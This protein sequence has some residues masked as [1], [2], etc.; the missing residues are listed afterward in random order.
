[1]VGLL[2]KEMTMFCEQCGAVLPEDSKFCFSCGAAVSAKETSEAPVEESQAEAAEPLAEDPQAEPAVSDFGGATE[3]TEAPASTEEP[4]A[5]PAPATVPEAA[6]TAVAA[7]PRGRVLLI[8]A[9]SVLLLLSLYHLIDFVTNI[10]TLAMNVSSGVSLVSYPWGMVVFGAFVALFVFVTGLLALIFSGKV[11]KAKFLIGAGATGIVLAIIR[12]V[13]GIISLGTY[14]YYTGLSSGAFYGEATFLL[15]AFILP[16]LA[17]LML[18]V[19]LILVVVGAILNNKPTGSVPVATTAA[20]IGAPGVDAAATG[21]AQSTVA[22]QPAASQAAYAQV[23]PVQNQAAASLP[24]GATASMVLGIVS[25]VIT[26]FGF[27]IPFSG[28]ISLITGIIGAI[29]G[30]RANKIA[31]S[32]QATLG[33]VLSVISLSLSALAILVSL[34]LLVFVGSIIGLESFL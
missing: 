21:A 2:L 25:I 16:L 12:F 19:S 15:T 1:L 3:A 17:T 7:K 20:A 9:G 32:P 6:P 31:K 24:E 11:A 23:A 30:S 13:Q 8:I 10:I 14:L 5:E 34:L 18:V 22:T 27:C 33:F 4:A 28:T 29:Q 26:F